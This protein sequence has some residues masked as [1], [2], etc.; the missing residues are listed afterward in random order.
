VN[1]S[2]EIYGLDNQYG[3]RVSCQ[4][5]GIQFSKDGESFGQSNDTM[6]DFDELDD[7][8]DDGEENPFG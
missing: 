1:V 4:L 5:N 6:G 2:L 8:D 7:D 3:K